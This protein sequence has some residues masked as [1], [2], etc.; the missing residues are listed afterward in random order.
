MNININLK[1]STAYKKIKPSP[2]AANF[3]QT[4]CSFRTPPPP[5]PQINLSLPNKIELANRVLNNAEL[6]LNS[7]QLMNFIHFYFNDLSDHHQNQSNDSAAFSSPTAATQSIGDNSKNNNNKGSSISQVTVC[8]PCSACSTKFTFE[9]TFQLHLNRRSVLIRLHCAQC[10]TVK[11]FFNRCKLLYHI[12]SHKVIR[13]I[14]LTDAV[15]FLFVCFFL[16]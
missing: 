15:I 12:F 1:A 16:R 3:Q 13:I 10:A 6:V 14:I 4:A 11:T 5:P 9:Q 2:A 7:L 8:F